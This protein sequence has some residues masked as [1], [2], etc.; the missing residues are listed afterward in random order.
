MQ[1]LSELLRHP[2]VWGLADEHCVALVNPS[3]EAVFIALQDALRDATDTVV[4]YFAGHGM[5]HPVTREFYLCLSGARLNGNYNTGA[6]KYADIQTTL[7]EALYSVPRKVVVLD[8]CYSAKSFESMDDGTAISEEEITTSGAVSLVSSGPMSTSTAKRGA[9]YTAYTGQLISVLGGGLPGGRPLLTLHEVHTE[10]SRRLEKSAMPQPRILV[11]DGGVGMSITRNV[12]AAPGAVPILRPEE[13]ETRLGFESDLLLS[14]LRHLDGV[15]KAV[16]GDALPWSTIGTWPTALDGERLL[17]FLDQSLI[18][19]GRFIA[20]S[21]RRIIWHWKGTTRQVSY[22]AL[23]H[24]AVQLTWASHPTGISDGSV[25]TEVAG[26]RIV[27]DGSELAVPTRPIGH[28]AMQTFLT[29]IRDAA[30]NHGVP[31]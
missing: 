22:G 18:F 14:V 27:S 3:R 6:I 10:V 9:E 26:V 24:M 20:F 15:P 25:R 13:E 5:R 8:T 1:R 31:D 16:T 12:Q 7:G 21:N 23:K 28:H 19:T 30:R 11:L 29:E 4:F 2:R 17:G